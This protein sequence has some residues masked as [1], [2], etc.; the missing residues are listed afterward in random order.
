[1]GKAPTIKLDFSH[2]TMDL[3]DPITPIL[4]GHT[5][6]WTEEPKELRLFFETAEKLGIKKIMA[7]APPDSRKAIEKLEIDIDFVFAYY[8]SMSYFGNFEVDKLLGEVD[9]AH[10]KGYRI[11][12]CWYGPRWLDWVERDDDSP[13]HLDDERLEPVFS[14]I[15]DCGMI[16]DIHGPYDPDLWYGPN[17]QYHNGKYGTKDGGLQEFYNLIKRHPNLTFVG[18][19]FGG[20]PEIS[21]LSTLDQWLNDLPNLC[22]DTASTRWMLR[23]LGRDVST[24]RDFIQKNDDRILFATDLSVGG[25]RKTEFEY[26]ASRYW[27]QRMFWETT[28]QFKLPFDDA[29]SPERPVLQGLGLRDST[30]K[31]FYWKNAERVFG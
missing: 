13:F 15:E 31:K 23:E 25:R 7:I 20:Q 22:I 9:E 12:K 2:L 30:L 5:H 26:F 21:R 10:S 18:V 3:P 6:V 24:S 28:S 4:D 8:M 11:M 1:M 14:H 16:V 29:D 27:S 17:G 19:H